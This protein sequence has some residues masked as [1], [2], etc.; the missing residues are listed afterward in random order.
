MGTWSIYS[1]GD[2]AFLEQ[3]LISVA[4]VTGTND[5]TRAASIALLFALIMLGFQ[6]INKGARELGFQQAFVGW[7]IFTMLFVPTT[8]VVLEDNVSGDVRVVSNVPFGVGAAGSIISQI[9]YKLT[10]LFETGYGYIAPYVTESHFAESLNLLNKVRDAAYDPRIMT[11]INQALPA[12]ADFRGSWDNYIRECTLTKIDLGNETVDNLVSSPL[13]ESLRFDSQLYGTR[14]Y[15]NSATGEDVTCTQGYTNL[16]EATNQ[17]VSNNFIFTRALGQ[18]LGIE[19]PEKPAT[20]NA[21]LKITDALQALRFTQNGA[22]DYIKASVLMPIYDQAV[23]GKYQ[24]MQDFSSAIMV[25]QA[26]QQRNTQW[27]SE[28]SMFMTVVR[29]VQTFFEG[30]IYAVTPLMAVLIIMGSYGFTLAFKYLQTLFWI[31]LWL[32]ILSIINLYITT[33]AAG[34]MS[35]YDNESMTS[36]FAMSG[37]NETLQNWIATGGMLA[38]ATPVISLFVV[39]GSTYAM[40]SI[41]GRIG[42]ADHVNEKVSTPD[43]VQPA[44]YMQNQAV[45]TNNPLTGTMMTGAEQ[46]VGNTTVGSTLSDSVQSAK[47]NQQ[48]SQESFS[49]ELGR[50]ASSLATTKHGASAMS[51]LGRT[52]GSMGTQQ[53]S[54]LERVVDQA[55]KENGWSQDVRNQV[56]GEAAVGMSAQKGDGG[57]SASAGGKAASQSVAGTTMTYGDLYKK[58]NEVGFGSNNAQQLTNQL[59]HQF[60]TAGGTEWAHT[61]GDNAT[62]SL[63]QSASDVLSATDSYQQATQ[64]QQSLGAVA[65]MKL[66]SVGGLL[67]NDRL[68]A[69]NPHAKDALNDLN[70]FYNSGLAGPEMQAAALQKEN[71]YKSLGMGEREAMNTAR[72]EAMMNPQNTTSGHGAESMLAAGNIISKATGHGAISSADPYKNSDLN[73]PGFSASGLRSEVG[74]AVSPASSLLIGDH[75]DMAQNGYVSPDQTFQHYENSPSN[76]AGREMVNS[77]YDHRNEALTDQAMEAQNQI[78]SSKADSIERRILRGDSTDGMSEAAKFFGTNS[79]VI[80][81]ISGGVGRWMDAIGDKLVSGNYTG[82][83]IDQVETGFKNHVSTVAERAQDDFKLDPA[84]AAYFST[85]ITGAGGL[86]GNNVFAQAARQE[87]IDSYQDPVLGEA[88]ANNIQQA[89]HAG[90]Q[91][92]AFLGDI[93]QHNILTKRTQ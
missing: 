25:N 62:K 1:V 91:A 22:V 52:V 5:F 72:L 29:P 33:A 30:F 83:M 85:L 35:M 61:L 34:E 15:L 27:A 58:L 51:S 13:P 37:V 21:F 63:K 39:T 11:A 86:A 73:G 79:N 7:L 57:V 87:V 32:P 47:L 92:G 17:S 84:Q 53:S 24:D 19:T 14:L 67:S 76:L 56:L 69:E 44:P 81:A 70:G 28:Q 31:Q 65:D 2:V 41:A 75:Y 50:T 68:L 89:V 16:I 71:L 10:N 48:Q 9:G 43:V 64:L 88:V 40:T 42:G 55:A 3:I 74:G 8:T 6:S 4:M 46:F 45:Q 93:A 66:N 77:E 38:A 80:N 49:K 82:N 18:A 54:L 59:A 26:I 90:P 78:R 20:E 36:M 12:G 23:M 60:T